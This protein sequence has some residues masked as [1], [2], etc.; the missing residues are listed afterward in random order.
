MERSVIKKSHEAILTIV[1]LASSTIGQQSLANEVDNPLAEI[2]RINGVVM[3][4]G[5]TLDIV[6][7]SKEVSRVLLFG[8][9][10]GVG[11]KN[12]AG[13]EQFTP[14]N[15]RTSIREQSSAYVA[16]PS[17]AYRALVVFDKKYVCAYTQKAHHP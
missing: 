16:S 14:E 12:I 3:Y 11:N 5:C 6:S 4:Q 2:T 10:A 7:T 15:N 1:M 17:I 9:L 13:H 8:I